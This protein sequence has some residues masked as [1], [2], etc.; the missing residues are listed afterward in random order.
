V[1]AAR[2]AA[3]LLLTSGLAVGARA[4]DAS[5]TAEILN[6]LLA[7]L[8]GFTE[9]SGDQLAREV[10][11][12]GG[13]AFRSQVPLD[14]LSRDGL[15]SY[16]GEVIDSEY[17]VEQA[18]ADQRLLVAF[19]LLEPESDLR[20]LRE[21]LLRENIA[22][23][24]DERPGRK[25]LYAVSDDRRLTPMNQVVLAHE[26]RHALQDQYAEVGSLLP[27]DVGDFDDRRLALMSLLEGDATLVMERF[28]LR[29]LTILPD[30]GDLPDL[31]GLS[32]PAPPVPGAPDVLR[33]QL[34]QPYLVGRD[35][36]QAVYRSGGWPALKAA[37]LDPPQSTE[38]VLHPEKFLKR[39]RALDV[40]VAYA[41]AAGRLLDEGV[42]GELLARTLLG[43]ETAGQASAGWGGDAFRVW[44]VAG[45]T[46]LVWRSV[47]DTPADAAEF[48]EAL[49][50]RFERS[51]GPGRAFEG[52]RLYGK[53]RWSLAL[54][55]AGADVTLV[56]SDD[57]GELVSA[58]RASR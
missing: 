17:P 49:R 43:E 10:E 31:S 39:E 5:E 52:A 34:L 19:G 42:L 16:L 29:R 20:A 56:A 51:H 30:D 54:G 46:L 50:G 6:A 41:P 32:L 36:A 40:R 26:L 18:L 14:Y 27:R 48:S 3:A 8:V 21:R 53:G 38:Q 4:Q 7:G 2:G 44:D 1:K 23:F 28:L 35:F 25:R 45:R 15:A 58:W 24:Y 12:A 55:E 9:M 33:D 11:E 47:W 57:A 22:G 13:V 37:W